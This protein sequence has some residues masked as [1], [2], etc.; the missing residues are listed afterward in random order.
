MRSVV[1]GI[2]CSQKKEHKKKQHNIEETEI[3]QSFHLFE[4]GIG[5]DSS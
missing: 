2:E 3:I 5:D 1:F 4:R